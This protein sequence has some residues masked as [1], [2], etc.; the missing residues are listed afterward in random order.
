MVSLNACSKDNGSANRAAGE[1]FLEEN[2]K[3]AGVITTASGLQYE[4][5]IA[6]TGS[7]PNSSSKVKVRYKGTLI[8]GTEFDSSST[9]GADFY[10]TSVI[11][12]WTEALKIMPVGSK[13]K[14]YI[15]YSLGYGAEANDDIPAYSVLIFEVEL[16]GIV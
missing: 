8:D 1:K 9:G 15:P 6:G 7:I 4:I 16:L 13:W 3:R 14:L 2:S 5:L 12:G 11:P 10:V